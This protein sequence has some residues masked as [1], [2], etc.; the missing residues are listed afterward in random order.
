MSIKQ[1]PK[2]TANEK[3]QV[4]LKRG[5]KPVVEQLRTRSKVALNISQMVQLAVIEK[6]EREIGAFHKEAV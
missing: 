6:Y 2:L 3:W 4:M 5:L 1:L